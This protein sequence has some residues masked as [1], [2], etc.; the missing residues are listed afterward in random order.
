MLINKVRYD[1]REYEIVYEL[2]FSGKR[3][4]KE[5][6]EGK[7]RIPVP[8][9]SPLGRKVIRAFMNSHEPGYP[10]SAA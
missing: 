7:E 3:K 5:I 8:S 2:P 10:D 6:Y 9:D 1:G 4:V